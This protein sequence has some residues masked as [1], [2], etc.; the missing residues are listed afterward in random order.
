MA[1]V[2]KRTLLPAEGK[3]NLIVPPPVITTAQKLAN[4]NVEQA[5]Y[6]LVDC[7]LVY[8]DCLFYP[9]INGVSLQPVA[10]AI[11]WL[12]CAEFSWSN[13]EAITEL[14]DLVRER[15]ADK[16]YRP[17]LTNSRPVFET[18]SRRLLYYEKPPHF[19]EIFRFL[20]PPLFLKPIFAMVKACIEGVYRPSTSLGELI[21][22]K[23][24]DQEASK[25]AFLQIFSH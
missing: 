20:V 8:H 12:T 7:Y 15:M 6:Y 19:G 2:T 22:T 24:I 18:D 9:E 4:K 11:S 5:A 23:Q 16:T 3:L 17:T 1:E 13:V 14:A 10:N 21:K 25:S